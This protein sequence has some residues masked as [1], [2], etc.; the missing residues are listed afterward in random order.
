MW[1]DAEQVVNINEKQC[2]SFNG[3]QMSDVNHM[4]EDLIIEY[5]WGF[6]NWSKKMDFLGEDF[7]EV[8]IKV[9]LDILENEQGHIKF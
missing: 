5:F 4:I 3:I 7:Y 9:K 1:L 8:G 2:E 6:R